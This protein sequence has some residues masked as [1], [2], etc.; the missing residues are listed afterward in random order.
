MQPAADSRQLERSAARGDA[1]ALRTLLLRH[2]PEIERTLDI[3]Q[4]W[5]SV[6]DPGDVMQVTYLEAFL[7]VDRFDP[8]RGEPFVHWL[9]RIAENNLRDAI[10]A[11]GRQKQP[12][13]D[14]RITAPATSA[15]ESMAAL[16]ELLGATHTTPSRGAVVAEARERLT[17]ALEA[18]PDGYQTAVRMYDLEGRTIEE[19]ASAVGKSPGAVHMMRARAHDR[20]RELLG[21]PSGVFPSAD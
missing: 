3:H 8:D 16:V 15:A 18:L 6:L 5:R 20:L 10:R 1:D 9:R 11:L 17:A 14:R 19:V 13:P 7:C 12:Q 21:A 2:G 4:K